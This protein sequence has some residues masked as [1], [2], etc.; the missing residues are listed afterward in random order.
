MKKKV[1]LLLVLVMILSALPMNVFGDDDAPAAPPWLLSGVSISG[2]FQDR[3]DEQDIIARLPINAL[4]PLLAINTTASP[5]NTMRLR[6]DLRYA[7]FGDVT[8]PSG[9]LLLGHSVTPDA[10]A[11]TP[12]SVISP[13]AFAVRLMS[14]TGTGA[15]RVGVIEISFLG[16]PGATSAAQV[17]GAIGGLDITLPLR[18]YSGAG[19]A[20]ST[21]SIWDW[22][23]AGVGNVGRFATNWPLA[24]FAD[25][26]VIIDVNGGARGFSSQLHSNPIRVRETRWGVL[27]NVMT[28]RLEAPSFYTWAFDAYDDV[29]VT[30]NA[31]VFGG[32]SGRE[33]Q[34][35]VTAGGSFFNY[36]AGV[37]A[38]RPEITHIRSYRGT[39]A[40]A[41]HRLYVTV[42][43]TRNADARPILGNFQ[44]NNLWLIPDGNANLTGNV[45]VE[46]RLGQWIAATGGTPGMPA[47]P[48]HQ[49][50]EYATQITELTGY[51]DV[52]S[53]ARFVA[54]DTNGWIRSSGTGSTP[55]TWAVMQATVLPTG[56]SWALDPRISNTGDVVFAVDP[57]WAI[58]P[59]N[60]SQVTSGPFYVYTDGTIDPATNDWRIVPF[61]APNARRIVIT[62]GTPAR[63]RN[64][65]STAVRTGNY[66]WQGGTPGVEGTPASPG[67]FVYG[68][69]HRIGRSGYSQRL[70]VGTRSV[71]GLSAHVYHDQYMRTGHLGQFRP[72]SATVANWTGTNDGTNH[73]Y[74][75]GGDTANGRVNRVPGNVHNA[76]L[77]HY[78]G[79]VTST[80]IIQENIAGAF[81]VGFGSPINF[82]FLDEDGNP[83]PGIRILGIQARAGNN[84]RDR[85]RDR[86]D[87]SFYGNN[88]NNWF[89]FAG[90]LAAID[91]RLPVSP[92]VG[93]LADTGATLYMTS[94][95]ITDVRNPGALEVRFFLSLEAGYEWKYGEG[96]YVTLSGAGITNLPEADRR[97]RIGTA[98]DP[99]QTNVTNNFPSIEVET[100]TLYNILG[101]TPIS[102]VTVDVINLNAF[103]IGSELW[104]YVTSDVLARARDLS[105]SGIPTL[106][107][108]DSALRFD[109]GRLVNPRDGI[110]A[111]VFTVTRMPN[112]NEQPSI[113]IS[114]LQVEGQV[115]PGVDYQI[116]VSGTTIANNDQVVYYAA[117]QRTTAYG[118]Q[119][120][121]MN[122]GV[123]TSLPYHGT[124]VSN[125]GE[126]RWDGAPGY[127]TPGVTPP[128]ANQEFRLQEG[129]PFGGVA[130]PLIWHIVGPN[131]VGMVS[132]RAF[133]VLIGAS[134]DQIVWD[135]E[136]RVAQIHGRHFN[137]EL[138]I[139]ISVQV[140]NTNATVQIDG[141][142]QT[143][144]I[145]TAVNFLSGPA[146]S[147]EPLFLNGVAYLPLRFVAETFGFT[148]ERQGNIVIFR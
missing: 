102:D 130:E 69:D 99:I 13:E 51:V 56:F 39:G 72:T 43:L 21:I 104:I 25:G 95:T 38:N 105:L 2:H 113:T 118:T 42:R 108:A 12:A 137:S 7:N 75:I 27:P 37:E 92:N 76:G 82:E 64:T 109:H 86:D 71:A 115:F 67:G 55:V 6:V 36:N 5:L 100:G 48:L 74:G 87:G 11:T 124:V 84:Y 50:W 15:H 23:S 20:N 22:E 106:T 19:W 14:V 47:V 132:M 89:T 88:R 29:T 83:H 138:T 70:H 34:L 28:L 40:A 101:R 30:G 145:A 66:T 143:V 65:T 146:G 127:G 119:M 97:V 116:V 125:D 78:T 73:I 136:N 53:N 139:G 16:I 17:A 111:V 44:L 142:N 46:A 131:R 90:W 135:S 1:A 141:V 26:N 128:L 122:R 58:D 52:R 126:G 94:Q 134:D 103:N 120:G 10:R 45:Y 140:G 117:S 91:Q 85:H 81:T 77:A 98:V 59:S 96:V 114:N 144:D 80:L 3:A 133:A 32:R 63:V 35:T 49:V 31:Q 107:V 129:V 61:N 147:V 112:A 8:I 110:A 123:F 18:A 54:V 62:Q 93:R 121:R 33:H 24:A 41:Q 9:G 57:I 60:P 68:G 148:V 79:V 4:I